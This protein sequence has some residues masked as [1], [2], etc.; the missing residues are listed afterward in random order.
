MTKR[1][2]LDTKKTIKNNAKSNLKL[3]QMV[4]AKNTTYGRMLLNKKGR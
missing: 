1:D 4:Y 2:F 3:N